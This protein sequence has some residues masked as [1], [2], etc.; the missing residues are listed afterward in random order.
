[1]T[2]PTSSVL[3]FPFRLVHT[4]LV[5]PPPAFDPASSIPS[6]NLDAD[7]LAAEEHREYVAS[8]VSAAIRFGRRNGRSF[9]RLP[10]HLRKWLMNLCDAGDPACLVVR[11]WLNGNR[12]YVEEL[13]ASRGDAVPFT[14]NDSVR[15]GV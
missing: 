2:S 12:H 11:D 8:I 5:S 15:E 14:R 6:L 7:T 4:A 10:S 9:S 1:M 3:P 13:S